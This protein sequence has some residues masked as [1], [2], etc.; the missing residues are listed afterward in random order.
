MIDNSEMSN[1]SPLMKE[2]EEA[3]YTNDLS[4]ISSLI[5]SGLDINL[6][7]VGDEQTP[8]ALACYL[9]N[10]AIIQTLLQSGVEVN[11]RMGSDGDVALFFAIL[12]ESEAPNLNIVRELVEAGADILQENYQ[13]D[14]PLSIADGISFRDERFQIIIDYFR[15]ELELQ[16]YTNN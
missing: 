16:K 10:M 1:Q 11:K 14:T 3:I 7:H 8:L 9:E 2:L 4:K 5:D 6:P 12:T 15:R 13:G